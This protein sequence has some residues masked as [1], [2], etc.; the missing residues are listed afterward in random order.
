MLSMRAKTRKDTKNK[1]PDTRTANAEK[2]A[3][4][5]YAGKKYREEQRLSQAQL[6][7]KSGVAR[8]II[9]GLETGRTQITTTMTLFKIAKALNVSVNDLFSQS[10]A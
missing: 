6:S 10:D 8:S 9:N 4:M 2:G 3:T 7:E 1:S 5:E